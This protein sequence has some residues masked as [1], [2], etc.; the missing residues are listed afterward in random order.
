MVTRARCVSS[1]LGMYGTRFGAR[2]S[3]TTKTM[4]GRLAPGGSA[5]APTL[6][7]PARGGGSFV[8]LARLRGRDREGGGLGRRR[9]AQRRD[10]SRWCPAS[11]LPE[12]SIPR[13]ARGHHFAG[14]AAA[15]VWWRCAAALCQA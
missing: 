8:T 5:G 15:A 7:A 13:L 1:T 6:P 11:W 3:V 2:S 14:R 4:L 10:A 9:R 12:N